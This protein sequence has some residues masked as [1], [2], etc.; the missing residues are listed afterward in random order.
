MKA[1]HPYRVIKAPVL[2]EAATIQTEAHNKYV[3]QVEPGA[4][5]R[6]IRDAIE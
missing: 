4:N 1:E 6:Q 3:F 5:K 2:S